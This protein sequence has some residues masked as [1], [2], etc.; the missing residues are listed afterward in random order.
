MGRAHVFADL[1]RYIDCAL[2]AS[3]QQLKKQSGLSVELYDLVAFLKAVEYL[4][5]FS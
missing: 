1:V 2:V 4:G 3:P 5:N